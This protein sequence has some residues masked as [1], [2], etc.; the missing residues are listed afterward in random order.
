M[1]LVSGLRAGDL[2]IPGYPEI[3]QIRV[4]QN[5]SGILHELSYG[6]ARDRAQAGDPAT[7]RPPLVTFRH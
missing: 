1:V 7:S 6:H 5:T 4:Y 3:V 2:A